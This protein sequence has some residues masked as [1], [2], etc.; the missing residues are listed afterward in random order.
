MKKSLISLAVLSVVFPLTSQAAPV[1]G[2]LT[3]AQGNPI[4]GVAVHVHGKDKQ[5]VT[6]NS[7][8]YQIDLDANSQLHFTKDGYLDKRLEVQNTTQTI[9]LV[10]EKSSIEAILNLFN[11]ANFFKE[12][13]QLSKPLSL[14]F[15]KMI[16]CFFLNFDFINIFAA[17]IAHSFFPA[18]HINILDN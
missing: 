13:C 15:G 18:I 17:F 7:G 9:N 11:L 10:L 14:L 12:G 6:D 8:N 5:V 4:A 3:D 1:S 2:Q 16:I